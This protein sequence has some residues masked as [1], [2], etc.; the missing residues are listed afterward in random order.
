MPF[1]EKPESI[2]YNYCVMMAEA[3]GVISTEKLY[4]DLGLA[5]LKSKHWFR[6]LCQFYKILNEKSASCYLFDT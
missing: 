6:N 3:I 4:H 1:H 5:S 2:Q